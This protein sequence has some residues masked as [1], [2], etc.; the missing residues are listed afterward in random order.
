ME[1]I[2]QEI[3][4]RKKKRMVKQVLWVLDEG[5]EKIHSDWFDEAFQGGT[6]GLYNWHKVPTMTREIEI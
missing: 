3:P 6:C 5:L 1:G 2:E 4:M